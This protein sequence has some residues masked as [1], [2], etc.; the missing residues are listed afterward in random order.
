M[1]FYWHA[2]YHKRTFRPA[3]FRVISSTLGNQDSPSRVK[4]P[5][6]TLFVENHISMFFWPRKWTPSHHPSSKESDGIALE[7][8]FPVSKYPQKCELAKI[9]SRCSFDLG[10]ESTS[11]D[12][13]PKDSDEIV[14]EI[15]VPRVEIPLKTLFDENQ[16]LMFFDLRPTNRHPKYTLMWPSVQSR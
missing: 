7:F 13:Y 14:L 3:L 15:W 16:I 5:A 11:H 9:T 2:T 6:E 1:L 10:S 12:L 8:E 4:T